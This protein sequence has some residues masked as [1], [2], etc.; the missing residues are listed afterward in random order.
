MPAL[1]ARYIPLPP[2][3]ET[4]F[5]KNLGTLLANGIVTFFEDENRTV[6][7]A[8]YQISLSPSNQYI[9]T[10]LPNPMVLSTIGGFIDEAGNQIIPYLFPYDGTPT[11]SQGVVSLYYITVDDSTGSEQLS[12]SAW[13]NTASIS[14]IE[15]SL[16]EGSNELLNPQ[17]IDVLFETDVTTP[18]TVYNVSGTNTVTEIAPFWN[19]ITTGT[20][21]VTVSQ[22]AVLDTTAPSNPPYALDINSTGITN[23]TLQQRLSQSPR[24]QANGFVSGTFVVNSQDGMAHQLIM[25]YVPS[26]GDSYTLV[27][28]TTGTSALFQQ[29]V[30]TKEINGIINTAPAT[31]GYVD[32][33]IQIPPSAHIQ[34]SSLQ[35]TGVGAVDIELPFIEQSTQVQ[36]SMNSAYYIPKLKFKQIPSLLAGWDFPVNPRQFA[37]ASISISSTAAYVWDQTIMA[38]STGFVTA[39][40]SSI[41]GGLSIDAGGGG[42]SFYMLQYLE[43]SEIKKILGTYLSSNVQTFFVAGAT[44]PVARIYLYRGSSSATIPTLPTSI[45]TLD[46]VGN[47]TLTASNWTAIPRNNQQIPPEFT[48][49]KVVT[50]SD[51]NSG[52]D[53]GFTGWQITDNTQIGDTTYFAMVVSFYCPS[54]STVVTV[55]SISLVPGLIATRPAPITA[56]E[57]LL[58]NNFYFEKSYAR[59]TAIGTATTTGSIYKQQGFFDAGSSVGRWYAK[60]FSIN[61]RTPKG[62]TA[63]A[64]TLYST[65]SGTSGFIYG[66]L[67]NNGAFVSLAEANVPISLWTQSYLSENSVTYTATNV[68]TT[69]SGISF[70]ATEVQPEALSFFQYTVDARSGV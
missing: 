69:A 33:L 48:L 2:I 15:Q 24:I 31:T 8:I 52:T 18:T 49:K 11:N 46:P 67:Y 28:F 4:I 35:L 27:T 14:P 32:I 13:P 55:N 51:M 10:Q 50:N 60:T 16:S 22:A 47:F 17:F 23:L 34:I 1:D 39:T 26:N 68:S 36:Q 45:G 59:G 20:G 19:I 41:T 64:V 38:T 54:A 25:Q 58:Q 65:A 7:K 5:D 57:A 21:T 3:Q 43:G 40:Q 44:A 6:L 66:Q 9:Y 62:R 30:G 61:Y 63:P 70:V 53:F 12:I 56:Q 42:V 37:A 29:A